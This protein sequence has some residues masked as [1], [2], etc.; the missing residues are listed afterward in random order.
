MEPIPPPQGY[1]PGSECTCG[2][3]PGGLCNLT[4]CRQPWAEQYRRSIQPTAWDRITG[5]FAALAWWRG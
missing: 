3:N 2:G 1:V 5:F 4:D